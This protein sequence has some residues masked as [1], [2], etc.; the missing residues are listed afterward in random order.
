[1]KIK[2]TVP[3]LIGLAMIGVTAG[4]ST[5]TAEGEETTQT[6][7]EQTDTATSETDAA[8]ETESATTE[9]DYADGTYEASGSYTSPG[10]Q[11]EVEV[12]ITLESDVISA[13][14]VTPQA[15]NPNS[16][17]YQQEFASGIAAEVVGVDL[18]D[19]S[20]SRVAGSS[21]TSGGFMAALEDIAAQAS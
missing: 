21:L 11:E 16:Q 18:D 6:T 8:I 1:M 7:P 9:S 17:R 3:A 20:V 10:G 12:S 15:T 19:V 14:E 5:P 4:C 13:V 2:Q